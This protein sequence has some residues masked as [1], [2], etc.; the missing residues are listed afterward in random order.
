MNISKSS[1]VLDMF[2]RK[3]CIAKPRF[4]TK[5]NLMRLCD[6]NFSVVIIV[7]IL[8]VVKTLKNDTRVHIKPPEIIN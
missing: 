3:Q 8:N 4:G 6:W 5:K 7:S 1:R 2:Q